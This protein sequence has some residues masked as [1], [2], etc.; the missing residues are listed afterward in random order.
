MR[1]DILGLM[2]NDMV[3]KALGEAKASNMESAFAGTVV[4]NVVNNMDSY[5]NTAK[6][7]EACT[8]LGA[9]V[10]ALSPDNPFELTALQ[11]VSAEQ[12]LKASAFTV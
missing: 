4:K 6:L 5:R 2:Q 1:F 9:S 10:F 11:R 7:E 8:A 12:A 3:T